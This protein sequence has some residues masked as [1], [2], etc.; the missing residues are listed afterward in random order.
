MS[1]LSVFFMR[2][3]KF[4][5]IPRSLNFFNHK[6][7]ELAN[8]F[9]VSVETSVQALS[10]ELFMW[11]ETPIAFC[12]V[13]PPSMPAVSPLGNAAQSFLLVAGFRLLLFC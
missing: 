4:S 3:R 7:A 5:F 13:S 11:C 10:S 9:P 6:S 1:L 8:Y 2:L 12:V